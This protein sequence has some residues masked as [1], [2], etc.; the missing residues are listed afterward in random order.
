MEHDGRTDYQDAREL[1]NGVQVR[2]ICDS[3]RRL[4][5]QLMRN[6]TTSDFRASSV[7]RSAT[8]RYTKNNGSLC[9]GW[10]APALS[11]KPRD[12]WIG[13]PAA[14]KWHR[15]PLVANNFRFLILPGMQ[16]ILSPRILALN[17][18]RLSQDWHNAYGH[19]IWLVKPSLIHASSKEP[20]TRLQDGSVWEIPEGSPGTP[21]AT[22]TTAAPSSY[23][24]EHCDRTHPRD[25]PIHTFPS[26][27][28]GAQTHETLHQKC[29]A[30]PGGT[31][32]HTRPSNGQGYAPQEALHPCHR[33]LCTR[34][35]CP[36]LCCH[37]SMGSSLLSRHAQATPV[38][39]LEENRTRLT[40]Q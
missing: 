39:S 25:F 8:W 21:V 16:Y 10:A 3:E 23:S 4:W 33:G 2:L 1:V 9:W 15:L 31:P 17:I 6:T 40:P 26:N 11:C 7:N 38:P 19:P 36:R 35:R 37:R 20:A 13:W 22:L 32:H 14:L 28:T 18:N 5:A 30:P 29:R 27:S 12:Q 24:S 34:L